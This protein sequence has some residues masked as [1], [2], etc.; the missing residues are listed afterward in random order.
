MLDWKTDLSKLIEDTK[1]FAKSVRVEPMVARA[2]VEL[3]RAP[4]VNWAGSERE[5]IGRYVGASTALQKGAGG[6]RRV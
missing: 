5:E 4:S 2:V 3:N 6:L 1:T